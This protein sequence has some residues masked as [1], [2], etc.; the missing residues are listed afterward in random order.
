MRLNNIK[1]F[2]LLLLVL[3]AI[4]PTHAQ[5]AVPTNLRPQWTVGQSATYE[6]WGKTEKAETAQ[7]LGQERSET[8]TF[9]SEG[10]VSWR[11]DAVNDDGSATCTMQLKKIVFTIKAGEMDPIKFD[12]DNPAG[13]RPALDNLMSAMTQTPLTI[14]VAAD[15]TIDKVEGIDE[16]SNAAGAEA[17]EAE[18]VP[19][20]LDF[21]ETAS[22][23]ATL[24]AAPAEAAT[25]QTW[26]ASNT[27]N[28]EDVFPNAETT[29]K[30]DTTFTLDSLGVI[31]G[32]P[33]ATIKTKSEVDIQVDLSDLPEGAPDI[34]IQISDTSAAGEVLFDLSRHE[35][36]ARNET[37]TYTASITIP[38]PRPDMPP[39]TVK[40]VETNQSQLLRT[41]EE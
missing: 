40:V 4:L 11:V 37:M 20:E 7:V 1:R 39:I 36:V 2:A 14:T 29:A 24:I 38:A 5:N 23:L 33:I 12:S 21:K 34:D 32:V 18:I 30:W 25:G 27:W 16:L 15:G 10:Q 8:T 17:Q 31:A 13:D 3:L 35:A 41:S 26:T 6:F 28:H 9:I 19:E 22:D